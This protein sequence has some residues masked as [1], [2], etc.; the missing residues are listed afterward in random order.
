MKFHLVDRI[1]SIEPGRR[2]VGVKNLSLAEEYLA[3]HFPAFPVL[4]GVLM[5]ESLVQTA[6]WLVRL[7]QGWSKSLIQLAAARNVRYGNFVAPGDSLRTEV[8]LTGIEGDVA[9]CKGVGTVG[10]GS[11]AVHGRFELRC[12]NVADVFG[13]AADADGR[14]VAELKARFRLIGGPA[15]LAAARADGA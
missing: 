9:K 3:D 1:E 11:T 12:R 6:A 8:E 15:A 14:I 2:I 7:E 4:P 5:L 10:D 13:P